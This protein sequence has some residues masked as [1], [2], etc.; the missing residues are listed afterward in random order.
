MTP[1]TFGRAVEAIDRMLAERHRQGLGPGLSLAVT[2][3]DELVATRTYGVANAD[4]GDPV[5]DRTLFQI[6]SITKHFTAVA[7]L[8]L[9]EQGRL[10]LD[11][12]VTRYLDWFEVGSR[13]ATS[14]TLHHLL[15]HTA[16]LVMMMDS[17]PSAWAQVWKLRDTDL[18]FEPGTRFSY[19]NVGYNVLQCVI[20][21]V[22]GLSFDAALRKLV[23]A[24]LG[25]DQTW[26]EILW[27]LYPRLA[28]GHK[29]SS[30]DD[31]PVPRP[32][33]QVVVNRY[34]VSQGCASVVTTA[35]DLTKFLRMFLR[36]GRG[37]DGKV[38]LSA[39]LFAKMLYPHAPFE[40]FFEGTM[41]GYGALVEQSERTHG[42]R[43]V[44]GGGENLGFEATMYGDLEAGVGVILFCNSFDVPWGE[45]RWC[46]DALAAAAAGVEL[47]ALPMLK[48][49]FA[50]GLG[51]RAKD[52]V[53]TYSS[54]ERSFTISDE[55]GNLR[56]DAPGATA[57]LEPVW[58]DSFVLPAAGFDQGLLSFSRDKDGRVVGA[59]QLGD[60]YARDE[61][62]KAKEYVLPKEWDAYLGH[63]RAFGSLVTNFRIFARKGQLWCQMYSGYGEEP[64]TDLGGGRFRR[65]GEAS[66]ETY[67]FDWIA[68]GKALRCRASGCDFYR[69]DG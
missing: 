66:P 6:G 51:E 43:R 59:A 32:E 22:T 35:A 28:D 41:Q 52:Y 29:Y 19:S 8:R 54:P 49:L 25:M 7:C 44:I 34:R 55:K 45:T 11:A 53:G 46:L 40:G 30:V 20:Q 48:P 15:T 65:G 63:Y 64:L 36:R 17:Y 62:P 58:G 5:T 18:G 60:V 67:A 56:F 13:F 1:R 37:D 39:E 57:L 24:P 12:P 27:D 31:R 68:S 50:E 10:D 9:A 42:H 69:V 38:F 23:F 14:V 3:R 2:T 26:G 47:P 21:T 4:R 16:G 61:K 33:R